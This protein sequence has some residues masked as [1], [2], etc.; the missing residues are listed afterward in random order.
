MCSRALTLDKASFRLA[1]GVLSALAI[2]LLILPIVVLLLTSVTSTASLKFPPEGLCLRWYASHAS[3]R[4]IQEAAWNSLLVA[5][6]TTSLSILF[7]A[8]AA[9][10]IGRS[11]TATARIADALFMSPLLLPAL[12]FGFGALIFFNRIGLRDSVAPLVLGH[13]IV[14][15]PFVIRNTVAALSHFNPAMLEASLSLGA[16]R[17]YTFW[18]VTLPSIGRGIGA[19]AFIAFMSSFDNIPVSLFLADARTQMLPI[20]LWELIDN[21][22]DVRTAAAAGV[23]VIVTLLLMLLVERLAGITRQLR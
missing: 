15:V 19:G 21:Q 7:G 10:A 12:A 6:W 16:S 4:Q 13:V 1:I 17:F 20:H 8:A 14:C 2:G 11:G 23:I 9:L 5:F 22:L 3:A 18:R